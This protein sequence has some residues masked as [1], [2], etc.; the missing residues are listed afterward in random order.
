[1]TWTVLFHP[2]FEAEYGALS[3]E[4]Q[5]EL[6]ARLAVLRQFGPT[7]G[8]PTV[9]TLNGSSFSNMKELRF[10][11]DD[12]VWRFAFAFDQQRRAIIL[13]GGDKEGEVQAKFYKKLIDVADKRFAAHV[14]TLRRSTGGKKKR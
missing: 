6:L 7:L 3:Q 2:E 12:G 1:M 4:I 11:A 9:D 10:N 5:N 8:R 14:A 13:V